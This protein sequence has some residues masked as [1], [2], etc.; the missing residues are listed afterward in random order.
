MEARR[1][2]IGADK[3]NA[4]LLTLMKTKRLSSVFRRN[5][6]GLLG[7]TKREYSY[8]VSPPD[9]LVAQLPEKGLMGRDASIRRKDELSH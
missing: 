3:T 4:A 7:T 9:L 1:R 8:P 6:Y 5:R 2:K